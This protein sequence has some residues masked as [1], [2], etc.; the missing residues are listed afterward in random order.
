MDTY[1]V[2][3][4]TKTGNKDEETVESKSKR[5]MIKSKCINCDCT[6]TRFIKSDTKV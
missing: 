1:C 6:K 2:R 5:T 3:C 4:R